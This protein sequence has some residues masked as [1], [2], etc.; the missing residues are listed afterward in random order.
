[1]LDESFDPYRALGLPVGATPPEIRKRF[2]QLAR[3]LH[4]D[5]RVGD[6]RAHEQFIAV[7]R[8]YDMLMDDD[9]RARLE[10]EALGGLDESLTVIS[11]FDTSLQKAWA[12]TEQGH[13][14]E[15]KGLC[16][17]LLRARPMEPKVFDLLARIYDIEGNEA[18][19]K[20]MEQEAERIR[21][22]R[23]ATPKAGEAER[24][25]A[26]GRRPAHAREAV[27]HRPGYRDIWTGE[28]APKRLWLAWTSALPVIACLWLVW[29]DAG[30]PALSRFTW[31][32]TGAAAAAGLLG[33]GMLAASGVLGSFDLHL[34]SPITE[35]GGSSV[36]MWLYLMVA[37]IVSAALSL[38]FYLVF[39]IFEQGFSKHV[40]ALYAWVGAVA[41]ALAWAHGGDWLLVMLVGS[42]V[43]FIGGLMGWMIGSALRPGEW[44]Q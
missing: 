18:L 6:G 16:A 40:L 12:L 38:V 19:Q 1:M 15:A 31:T 27:H 21:G 26:P 23:A 42:N 24:A 13:L 5:V 43:V 33:M 7:K 2:R 22:P 41:A 14:M 9:M 8:A 11:D 20:R 34:G 4:P 35:S 36:P 25:H 37:G 28:P 39:A 30:Q 3:K 44:W 29:R 32:E 17:D 10:A